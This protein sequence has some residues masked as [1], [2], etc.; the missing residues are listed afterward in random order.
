MNRATN[1]IKQDNIINIYY[2]KNKNNKNNPQIFL[3]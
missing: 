3:I 2:K 1:Q